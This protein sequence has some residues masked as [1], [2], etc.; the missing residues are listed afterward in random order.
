MINDATLA[1]AR[2]VQRSKSASRSG[3][4]PRPNRPAE[5]S[6][7]ARLQ[8]L[9]VALWTADEKLEA[10]YD[11]AERGTAID[12]LLRL[13]AHD[14]L[15]S[16]SR[17]ML[18][19]E[20]E[21]AIP[22]T[23]VDAAETYKALFPVLAAL[24][25]AIALATGT[26][27][28]ATLT[29]ALD[30][31]NWAQEECDAVALG[32]LLPVASPDDCFNRGRDLAIEMLEQGQQLHDTDM[33]S[34]MRMFRPLDQTGSA[35]AQDAFVR[36]FLERVAHDRSL[37]AGFAAVLSAALSEDSV[38]KPAA[39]CVSR[40]EFLAGAPGQDGTEAYQEDDVAVDETRTDAM[41]SRE[42]TS[43]WWRLDL[44]QG[45]ISSA[46]VML[47]LLS[48]TAVFNY[49]DEDECEQAQNRIILLGRA[50]DGYLSTTFT[51][52]GELVEKL[53]QQPR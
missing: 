16:A 1:P 38:Y 36:P 40:A 18:R 25:G 51:D 31:L 35:P 46:R 5:L 23:K 30:L 43:E 26:V 45:E 47:H 53:R 6:M 34:G 2:K 28:A 44:L 50:V 10:A 12:G 48:E 24:Q 15:C 33:A 9:R 42:D 37:V 39:Y 14:L 11:A 41:A 32:A 17:P 3:T 13:I 52:L 49:N 4:Q 21:A 7:D 8:S 19:N 27:L 29:D 20:D 22:V